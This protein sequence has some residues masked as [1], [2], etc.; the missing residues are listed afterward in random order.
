M[1][2]DFDEISVEH[3]LKGRICTKRREELN[4]YEIACLDGQLKLCCLECYFGREVKDFIVCGLSICLIPVRSLIFEPS[5]GRVA[6]MLSMPAGMLYSC[7]TI[8]SI[9]KGVQRLAVQSDVV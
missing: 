4:D 8:P 5:A 6:S 2:D 9:T 7:L 1:H 3:L